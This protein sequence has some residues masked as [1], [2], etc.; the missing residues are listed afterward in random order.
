MA[1][2]PND[3]YKN[4][5]DNLNCCVIIPTYNNEQTVA[6]LITD[7]LAFTTNIIVINDG[8]T[9]STSEILKSFPDIDS[10]SYLPNK[11]KGI[12]LRT[13]FKHAIDKE[14]RYAITIDSDGQHFADD[15]PQFIDKIEQ[16]PDSLLIGSRNLNQENMPKKNTFGNKFSNFWFWFQTGISLPDTQSGYRLYPIEKMKGIHYFTS[17]FEFEIEVMVKAAWHEIKITPVP[18]KVFYA[19]KEK[20][21]THFRPFKDFT[22]I[23]ILNTWLVILTLL[24]YKPIRIL[25]HFTKKNIKKMLHKHFLDSAEPVLNKSIAVAFGVFM[26]II[27]IWGFQF[28][29]ALVLA[30]LMKI[31]KAIVGLA[32]QISVPPM[33]PFLLY[34]SVKTGQWV[35]GT[36]TTDTVFTEHLTLDAV[37]HILYEYFFSGRALQHLYEYLIGSVIFAIIMAILLGGI[38]Y[39][40]LKIVGKKVLIKV[41]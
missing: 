13:G 1:P 3:L 20:R 27:P 17:K 11:G 38:T 35:L 8:S 29:S 6:N 2:S 19:E 30:H 36:K 28:L 26:G 40:V 22:R 37:K 32:A 23:S 41:E 10:I 5:I 9:D 16:E 15:L 4:K 39:V 12:A 21:I 33:I 24:W 25:K 31:N 7:V 18:I 34:G 14:Y